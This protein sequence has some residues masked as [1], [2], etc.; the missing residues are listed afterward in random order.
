LM[1]KADDD[2]AAHSLLRLIHL[3]FFIISSKIPGVRMCSITWLCSCPCMKMAS[4]KW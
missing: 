4:A 3:I 1:L 2:D